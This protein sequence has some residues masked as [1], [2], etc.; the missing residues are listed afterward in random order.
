MSARK[1]GL[2][3]CLSRTHKYSS[4]ES[5]NFNTIQY[6]VNK[7]P[8]NNNNDNFFYQN[9]NNTDVYLLPHCMTTCP[10]HTHTHP[11][12]HVLSYDMI[13][14]LCIGITFIRYKTTIVSPS[15]T[16]NNYSCLLCF[17]DFE[18]LECHNQRFICFQVQDQ[19]AW[20]FVVF[21][22]CQKP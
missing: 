19:W 21:Q 7:T 3:T 2:N 22:W 15:L 16:A 5:C 8:Q 1:C 17:T 14:T 18:V 6:N 12:W 10:V 13:K 4:F 20:R 11:L 9:T